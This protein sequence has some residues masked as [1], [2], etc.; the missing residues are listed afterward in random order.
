MNEGIKGDAIL[1]IAKYLS[2]EPLFLSFAFSWKEIEMVYNIFSISNLFGM[3]SY[4]M[5][6]NKQESV[7]SDPSTFE[8]YVLI[9]ICKLGFLQYI[10]KNDILIILLCLWAYFE[11]CSE[12]Q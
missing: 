6:R 8:V 1:S 7:P 12:F 11:I 10:N 9:S 2:M 3:N 4:G 5:K